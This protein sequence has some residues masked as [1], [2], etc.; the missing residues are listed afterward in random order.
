MG[1]N[2]HKRLEL[3]SSQ[4]LRTMNQ[5][6]SLTCIIPKKRKSRIRETM[7]CHGNIESSHF[8]D[9][10]SPG[11]EGEVGKQCG[12]QVEVDVTWRSISSPTEE[13]I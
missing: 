10:S 2:Y 3:P 1:K 9:A 6:W 13:K 12:Y 5:H 7:K 11:D 8:G 4:T